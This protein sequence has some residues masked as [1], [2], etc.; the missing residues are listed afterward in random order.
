M[1]KQIDQL[2][3]NSF[4]DMSQGELID[5]I[6]DL[7]KS[8]GTRKATSMKVKAKAQQSKTKAEKVLNQVSSMSEAEKDALR[9]IIMGE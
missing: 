3:D 7:R 4:S 9:K 6:R 1:S 8:R 2:V 5:F